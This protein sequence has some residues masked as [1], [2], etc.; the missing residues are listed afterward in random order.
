MGLRGQTPRSQGIS[1]LHIERRPQKPAEIVLPGL[2]LDANLPFVEVGV[3]L[4]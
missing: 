3:N 2:D 4:S 1:W